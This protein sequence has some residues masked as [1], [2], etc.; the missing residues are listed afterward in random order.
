MVHMASS[1]NQP[2]PSP[3]QHAP[4]RMMLH[5]E[6]GAALMRL[7]AE[8]IALHEPPLAPPPYQRGADG[9]CNPAALP[10]TLST[11]KGRGAAASASAVSEQWQRCWPLLVERL[12][13]PL[14]G[15][16]A[17]GMSCTGWKQRAASQT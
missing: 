5:D 9:A 11:F 16:L 7:A 4:C 14:P 2:S 6:S 10:G 3:T 8:G 12:H 13:N 1:P 15:P 17:Q